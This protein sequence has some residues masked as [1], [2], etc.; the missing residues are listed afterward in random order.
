[1]LRHLKLSG[2]NEKELDCVYRTVILPV[3]DYCCVIYPSLLT[4]EQDQVVERLQSRALKNIY[5]FKMKYA[6]MRERAGVTT[7]RAR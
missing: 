3:L 6:D 4:D 5:G 1:M 2:F 7:L